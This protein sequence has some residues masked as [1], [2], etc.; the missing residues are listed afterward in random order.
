MRIIFGH[1]LSCSIEV[2]ATFTFIKNRHSY[3]L[4]KS[5]KAREC[6]AAGKDKLL[7]TAGNPKNSLVRWRFSAVF[8]FD[9]KFFAAKFIKNSLCVN[10]TFW[11]ELKHLMKTH[12]YLRSSFSTTCGESGF[13]NLFMWLRWTYICIQY[14]NKLEKI[15]GRK[16]D[17]FILK[18]N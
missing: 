2:V 5:D 1:K 12:G 13:E 4:R 16:I 15:I 7:K 17:E 6:S 14:R 11:L 9:N 10:I 18:K 3:S 8:W